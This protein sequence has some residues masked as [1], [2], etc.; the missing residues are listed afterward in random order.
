MRC[1]PG[2]L[3]W[4]VDFAQSVAH[5]TVLLRNT[6]KKYMILDGFAPTQESWAY[7]TVGESDF[8]SC[9]RLIFSSRFFY[10]L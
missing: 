2:G 3:R 5:H 9:R 4:V 7:S 8:E 1:K 6:P 10:I